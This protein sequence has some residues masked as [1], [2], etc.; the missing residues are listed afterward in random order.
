[1]RRPQRQST[2]IVVEEGIVAKGKESCGFF[3][4]EH[5]D[6][7]ANAL[8]DLC[9]MHMVDFLR[10]ILGFKSTGKSYDLRIMF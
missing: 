6:E 9:F 7:L 3:I 2:V 5:T 1:M 10:T 4:A 8:C